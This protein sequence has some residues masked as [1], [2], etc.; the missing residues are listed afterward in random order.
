MS[1][2]SWWIPALYKLPLLLSTW[3]IVDTRYQL[4]N[5]V[6]ECGTLPVWTCHYSYEPPHHKV[7][8]TTTS[9][10]DR[11]SRTSF[12]SRGQFHDKS[13]CS[14][15]SNPTLQNFMDDCLLWQVYSG[16]PSLYIFIHI[17][18]NY[19]TKLSQNR[20]FIVCEYK[21]RR[22]KCTM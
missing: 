13:S 17:S 5:Y 20:Q 21:T 15:P 14:T 12:M 7:T 3:Q 1:A 2:T 16:W 18:H 22:M 11:A 6:S 19:F 4:Y 10:V 8:N 9:C